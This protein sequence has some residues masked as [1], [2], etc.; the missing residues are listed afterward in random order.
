[1]THER[2]LALEV[3]ERSLMEKKGVTVSERRISRTQMKSI[4]VVSIGWL[5]VLGP[6]AHWALEFP[7]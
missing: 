1:M 2:G 4:Q 6:L 5:I 3:I 7:R